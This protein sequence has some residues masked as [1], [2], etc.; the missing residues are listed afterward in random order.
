MAPAAVASAAFALVIIDGLNGIMVLSIWLEE[1]L[2]RRRERDME[3]RRKEIQAAQAAA[4]SARMEAA[5]EVQKR[6]EEWNRRREAAAA[7]GEGI[8]E[9]PPGTSENSEETT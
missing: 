3:R 5:A 6:W 7:T 9:P 2:E 1:V 8:N 4:E